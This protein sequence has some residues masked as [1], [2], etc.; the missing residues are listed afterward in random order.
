MCKVPLQSILNSRHLDKTLLEYLGA[1]KRGPI[2]RPVTD[3]LSKRNSHG[4]NYTRTYLIL[5]SIARLLKKY[6]KYIESNSVINHLLM[7]AREAPLFS[8]L[9]NN[10][11]VVLG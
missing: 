10:P 4:L 6:T 1:I 8:L 5:P 11:E 9:K 2:Q 3:L 7:C